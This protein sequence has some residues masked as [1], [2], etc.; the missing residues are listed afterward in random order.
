[1]SGW[2]ILDSDPPPRAR[3]QA[4]STSLNK[5]R[6]LNKLRS[7]GYSARGGVVANWPL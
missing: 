7:P 6:P 4:E 2:L 5:L 1:M 3:V